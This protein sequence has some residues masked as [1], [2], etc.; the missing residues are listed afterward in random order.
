MLGYNSPIALLM[1]GPAEIWQGRQFGCILS[2]GRGYMKLLCAGPSLVGLLGKTIDI[3]TSAEKIAE[4]IGKGW[5]KY[6]RELSAVYF[7][8]NV[9]QDMEDIHLDE[10][11]KFGK[12]SAMTSNYLSKSRVQN[13]VDLCAQFI[14][15]P[16]A[17]V[18][19]TLYLTVQSI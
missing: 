10:Y 7:S 8:F 9:E 3:A 19:G 13:D 11:R 18:Q 1:G 4:D 17:Q 5:E 15:Y 2:I 6:S 12:I 16:T 14:K